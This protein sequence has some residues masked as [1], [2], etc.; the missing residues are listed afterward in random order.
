MMDHR[1]MTHGEYV[2]LLLGLLVFDPVR[3]FAPQ[4]VARG[5]ISTGH[6]HH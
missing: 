2:V 3:C 1:H 6:L 4:T 5:A